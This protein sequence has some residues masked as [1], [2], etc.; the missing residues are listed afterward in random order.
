[1]SSFSGLE[2]ADSRHIEEKTAWR[3]LET[4]LQ[5][6]RRQSDIRA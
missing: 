1:M 5:Q 3:H 6:N 4:D 2:F